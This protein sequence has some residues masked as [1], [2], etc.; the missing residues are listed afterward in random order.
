MIQK[1]ADRTR[2]KKLSKLTHK[3]RDEFLAVLSEGES[4]QSAAN[5]IAVSRQAVYKLRE[6]DDGFAA[7][8]D[9]A[10]NSGTDILEDEAVRRAKKSSDVLLMFLLKGRRPEKYK[11]RTDITSGGKELK[12]VTFQIAGA[13]INKEN[14]E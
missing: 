14:G 6:T 4:V 7:L 3:K 5:A 10:I 8:W 9:G 13:G 12:T 1:I 2:G 11:D